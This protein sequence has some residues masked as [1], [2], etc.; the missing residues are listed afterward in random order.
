[1]SEYKIKDLKKGMNDVDIIVEIDF[2]GDKCSY[3]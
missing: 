3:E 2:M 1:M